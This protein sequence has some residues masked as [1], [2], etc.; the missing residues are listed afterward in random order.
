VSGDQAGARHGEG[1]TLQE[2]A[3]IT[4]YLE[5]ARL[6]KERPVYEVHLDFDGADCMREN[7]HAD[8]PQSEE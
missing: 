6:R 2:R 3:E 1:N 4:A 8:V 5:R 7:G